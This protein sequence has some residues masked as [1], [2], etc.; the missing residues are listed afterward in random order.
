MAPKGSFQD[1][2]RQWLFK[3]ELLPDDIEELSH[4]IKEDGNDG[5]HAGS[6]EK[7]DAE[8]LEAGW[9]TKRGCAWFP[10]VVNGMPC[11]ISTIYAR[12]RQRKNFVSCA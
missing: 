6:L 9:C 4:C 2:R 3:N 5:A 1:W 8:E 7:S 10:M 12:M 11:A